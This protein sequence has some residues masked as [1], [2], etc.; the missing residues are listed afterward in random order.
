MRSHQFIIFLMVASIFGAW[1]GVLQA[2]EASQLQR[3]VKVSP[4]VQLPKEARRE[5]F[6]E[7][8]FRFEDDTAPQESDR[9]CF[10]TPQFFSVKGVKG[11][12][13]EYGA[14]M[15]YREW[16]TMYAPQL[17]RLGAKRLDPEP[18]PIFGGDVRDAP[19]REIVSLAGGER[20]ALRAYLAGAV[21]GLPEDD[22][23]HVLQSALFDVIE[24]EPFKVN[25]SC[26]EMPDALRSAIA[27]LIPRI[28]RWNLNLIHEK[29]KEANDAIVA[30]GAAFNQKLLLTGYLFDQNAENDRRIMRYEDACGRYVRLT[31]QEKCSENMS[32]LPDPILKNIRGHFAGEYSHDIFE[33]LSLERRI[34][35]AGL[36]IL[37]SGG[38]KEQPKEQYIAWIDYNDRNLIKDERVAELI[39]CDEENDCP[40]FEKGCPCDPEKINYHAGERMSNVAQLDGPFPYMWS[41]DS[42]KDPCAYYKVDETSPVYAGLSDASPD[43]TAFYCRVTHLIISTSKKNEEKFMRGKGEPWEQM[44]VYIEPIGTCADREKFCRQAG[45]QYIDDHCGAFEET[46][47][48]RIKNWSFYKEYVIQYDVRF[49]SSK[50][51]YESVISGARCSAQ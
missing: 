24:G 25:G 1:S 31:E 12:E 47:A 45:K 44:N 10:F 36:R 11:R 46:V 33:E 7:R 35:I 4:D 37:V 48:E 27:W 14:Q 22:P 16:D 9:H 42:G 49:Y 51:V 30:Q 19:V 43:L 28:H 29:L 20:Q 15:T 40:A 38:K 6:L 26:G 23:F 13:G 41:S 32:W 34:P 3:A 2:Q 8:I 5:S 18:I 39:V 17:V 21:Q 50:D